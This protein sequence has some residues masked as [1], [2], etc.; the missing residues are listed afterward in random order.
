[1]EK[2][3]PPYGQFPFFLYAIHFLSDADTHSD[4]RGYET[5]NDAAAQFSQMVC[6]RHTLP[7]DSAD[8]S[9]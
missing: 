3:E 4:S 5:Y 6:K 8:G 9:A 7:E 2:R 1:M